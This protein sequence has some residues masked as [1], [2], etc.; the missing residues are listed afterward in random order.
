VILLERKSISYN[1]VLLLVLIGC[2]FRLYSKLPRKQSFQKLK[3]I[4][5]DRNVLSVTFYLNFTLANTNISN[6]AIDASNNNFAPSNDEGKGAVD[7]HATTQFV[8]DAN[9][10][11]ASINKPMSVSDLFYK[12]STTSSM[13]DI[14]S[15]LRKPRILQT[16]VLSTTDTFSTFPSIPI[17]QTPLAIPVV[18]NKVSGFFGIR[19]KTVLTWQINGNR[20]QQGR[21]MLKFISTA[22]ESTGSFAGQNWVSSHT[23][24]L[25]QRTQLPGIELDI[26]CDTQGVF[27]IPYVSIFNFYPLLSNGP[28]MNIGQVQIYPYSP[29]VAPTGSTTASYTIWVHFED[30]EL[31]GPANP[32][33]GNDSNKEA[34]SQQV[35]PVTATLANISKA[36]NIWKEV[37]LLSSY[38]MGASWFTGLLSRTTDVFGWSK[39][40]NLSHVQRVNRVPG[41]YSGNVDN[42]DQALPVSFM[43]KNQV[44]HLQ[45]YSGTDVDE[46]DFSF[47]ASIPAYFNQFSWTESQTQATDIFSFNV[48]PNTFQSTR[49]QLGAKI[50]TDYA[51]VAFVASFFEMWRGSIV[52][53][54]KFVKTEFHSGRLAIAFFPHSEDQ[55]TTSDTL[56][57]SDYVHREI[58]DIREANIVTITIPYISENP[59]KASNSLIPSIGT[60]HVFVVDPL[61][62]P[63]S[64]S[65]TVTI[66]CEASGGPDIEFAIPSRTNILLPVMAA[67]PQCGEFIKATPESGVSVKPERNECRLIE[68][69]IGSSDVTF[70]N[71]ANAGAVIGERISSFRT[72]LKSA[73]LQGFSG[74]PNTIPGQTYFNTIPFAIPIYFNGLTNP[75]PSSNGDIYSAIA[76]CYALGR[77]G[78]RVRLM[79]SGVTAN[80][81]RLQYGY[82]YQLTGDQ[83]AYAYMGGNDDLSTA[84]NQLSVIPLVFT[85]AIQDPLM[86]FQIPQYGMRHSRSHASSMVNQNLTYH[87]NPPGLAPKTAFAVHYL[88]GITNAQWLR[89]GG[90]D[91]TFGQFVSI[92]PM[93][94]VL[95]G[96]F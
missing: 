6:L 11:E 81:T 67:T 93:T 39:P 77:G 25:V 17:P 71:Y 78:V 50:F 32:Q 86:E 60:I 3:K 62:A 94:G 13:E 35:G 5:Y 95:N 54:F 80:P 74:V 85:N 43:V 18:A 64:V 29:I 91:L 53:T 36:A 69:C 58:V 68:T 48:A 16:G 49:T 46:M 30:V 2:L 45:G 55:T 8:S 61:V 84:A 38:A 12:S 87:T 19:M 14:K 89:S 9:I 88:D 26:N 73:S 96:A 40:N 65:S 24:T 56:V 10:A 90:D 83:T 82:T 47:V 70:D 23:N 72:L 4:W 79:V 31:V 22:G 20:F 63:S 33:A 7:I 27:E 76:G 75:E 66:L 41:V 34:N 42:A 21:Y 1:Q 37:P 59:F 92:P 28:I 51:P 15:F 57:Q 44:T 52:I